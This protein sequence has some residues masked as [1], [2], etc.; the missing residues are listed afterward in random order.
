MLNPRCILSRW[1]FGE[2]NEIEPSVEK[3]TEGFTVLRSFC[4]SMEQTIVWDS[5]QKE[6]WFG[7]HTANQGM[8]FGNLPNWAEFIS[9]RLSLLFE[10]N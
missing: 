6:G 2:D 8:S 9:T 3:I 7:P 5:I 4:S 10:V 1:I